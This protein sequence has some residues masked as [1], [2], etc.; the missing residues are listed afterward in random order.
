VDDE[1]SQ[2]GRDDDRPELLPAFDGCGDLVDYFEA[3]ARIVST[4]DGIGIQ[5]WLTTTRFVG[6]CLG[7]EAKVSGLGTLNIVTTGRAA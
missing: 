3:V 4:I 2:Q 1:A 7:C 6:V 5:R